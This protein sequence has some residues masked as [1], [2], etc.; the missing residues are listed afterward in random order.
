MNKFLTDIFSSI[1]GLT[2]ISQDQ[3][4]RI[5]E[6]LEMRC[7]EKVHA[8]V[9][10]EEGLALEFDESVICDVCRSVRIHCLSSVYS[11]VID[12]KRS[13]PSTFSWL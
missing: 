6:E 8:I 12:C 7:W 10:E 9:K 2:P 4:E 13:P 5:I 11:S 1:V 3:L